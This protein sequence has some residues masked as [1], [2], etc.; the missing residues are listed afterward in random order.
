MKAE[1]DWAAT[2]ARAIA[3]SP[4]TRDFARRFDDPETPEHG[5]V[6]QLYVNWLERILD[7][8]FSDVLLAADQPAPRPGLGR[9][10]AREFRLALAVVKAPALLLEPGI[11]EAVDEVLAECF[12]KI[13]EGPREATINLVRALLEHPPALDRYV[14]TEVEA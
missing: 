8:P 13:D 14:N 12:A 1:P 11:R 6:L 9:S 7:G 5:V 10:P 4:Q 3:C 2:I